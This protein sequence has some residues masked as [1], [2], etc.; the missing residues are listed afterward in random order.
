M[1]KIILMTGCALVLTSCTNMPVVLSDQDNQNIASELKMAVADGQEPVT[2]AITLYEAMARA[3]KY[4]L[5]HRVAMMEYDLAARD[6]DLSKYDMLPQIVANGGY[7]GRNNDAGSSSLSLLSGR[8]SLEPSTSTQR[9]VFNT[10]LTMSWN[11]LD[12]GMS[13]IRSEQLGDESLIYQERRRKAIIQLMED[14]HRAYW[15]AASAQRLGQRLKTLEYD[16]RTAFDQSRR[17]FQGRRTAPM[18]ALSYQREL[19][20]ITAQAQKM[21]RELSMAKIELGALMNLPAGTDFSL[22][23]PTHMQTPAKLKMSF[24]EMVDTALRNRP[25]IRE[26][27]YA[28]RIGNGEIRKAVLEALPGIQLFGGVNASTNDFLYNKDWI[29]YGA[30]ASWNLIKVFETPTR[31]RRAQAKLAL[32]K[33][34]ALAAAM[35]VMTQVDIA[36]TR[37]DMLMKEYETATRGTRVQNDI[38][39]QILAMSKAKSVSRQTLVREQMNAIISEAKRDATHAEL[40]EASAK[41]YT[42]MGYDPYAAN[43]TGKEDIQTLSK[44]LRVLW[45]SR[46]SAQS[47]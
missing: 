2:G 14:V 16:V 10:D 9:D 6:Y 44:S 46:T 38:L 5:D 27:S 7:Y 47:Q 28:V 21:Q 35:A 45:N 33:E 19:N 39:K 24:E 11:I 34:R 42:S 43:I 37:Y 12:F 15:R 8:Q 30:K 13:K 41:I 20:D 26:S 22:S 32:E 31:K 18:P 29:S 40:R 36:R 1:R 23:L 3:L 17:L 25:E 4:N